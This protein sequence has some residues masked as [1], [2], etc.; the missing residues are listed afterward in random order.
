MKA[1]LYARVSTEEQTEGYSIDAQKRAF[2]SLCESKEWVPYTEYIEAGKSA[3]T[4]DIRKRPI[5]KQAIDDA[6]AGQYDVLV[7]HKIDRFSRKL[8]ITLDYFEKLGKAGVGFVSIEN[9]LDY[10]TPTGKFML[11]MQG[12]L[13]ELYSDNL[14]QETKKGWA[15]RRKQGLYCGLLPFGVMKG[16]D[17]IPVPDVQP[18]NTNGS[19]TTNY[20]GLMLAFELATQGKSDREIAE[21]I[22]AKGYRT[23]G[24]QGSRPFSKDTVRGILLNRFY[25][26]EIG[27]GSG[28]YIEAKHKS[29]IEE[30]V[31]KEAQESRK[32][33][34][35]SPRN[36]PAG[37]TLS[38]LTGYAY[39]WH[40]KAR[41]HTGTTKNGKKRIACSSRS[42]GR[43]CEQ[44]S[45]LIEV[46]EGQIE[47]FLEHFHI[48]D[49]YQKKI[50]EAHEKLESAYENTKMQKDELESRLE[51]NVK[52]F[53]WGDIGE[54]EYLLEKKKI[55]QEL[56]KL[57]PVNNSGEILS[58]LSSLLANAAKAWHDASQEQRNAL[59]RQLFEEVWI[60]GRQV[61]A[62]KPRPELESFFSLSYEESKK[63][64][65]ESAVLSPIG[66]ATTRKPLVIKAIPQLIV[67]RCESK[68]KRGIICAPFLF[69][70]HSH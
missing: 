61:V 66:V 8:R 34:R 43:G 31:W 14:S 24:N 28:G 20:D 15:E 26:G 67:Y 16:E 49:D 9:D 2:R 68:E 38:S 41:M 50:L 70:I 1:A 13:A 27:D 32:R 47:A 40:C 56:R 54:P 64:A 4:D 35:K 46:Y 51:R 65:S 39:C 5:F 60:E 42:Q 52:L 23:T 62:V 10:S 12:G 18:V 11:V 25:I 17:G 45:A 19:T 44:G 55:E 7:V 37:A 58:A 53:R 59:G 22:N 29:L 3:H 69:F 6:F 30:T 63:K 57:N 48:P 21:T 36:H 33:N